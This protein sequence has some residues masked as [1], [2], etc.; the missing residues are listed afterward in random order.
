M[1]KLKQLSYLLLQA[2]TTIFTLLIRNIK[3]K[4]R[5]ENLVNM[6][7]TLQVIIRKILSL[8]VTLIYNFIIRNQILNNSLFY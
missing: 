1:I 7:I 4:E 5:V 8:Q 6:Q 3:S 2:E